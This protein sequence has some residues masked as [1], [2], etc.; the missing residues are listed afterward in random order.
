VK[1]FLLYT[2]ARVALFAAAFGLVW[3]VFGRWIEWGA[4]SALYTAIIAM[5]VSSVVA[6]LVLGSLR[7]EFAVQVSQRADRAKAA[8]EARRAAEDNDVE[9]D[10]HQDPRPEGG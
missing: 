5:V 8:F 1:P 10:D 6:L 4:V 9:I 7:D 3:L 2:L